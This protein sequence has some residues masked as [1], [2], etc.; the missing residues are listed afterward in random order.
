MVYKSMVATLIQW[1]LYPFLSVWLSNSNFY[2]KPFVYSSQILVH[3]T[4]I[5][6]IDIPTRCTGPSSS[7]RWV[8]FTRTSRLHTAV[9]FTKPDM[10]RKELCH[11]VLDMPSIQRIHTTTR[12]LQSNCR[13][14]TVFNIC[15][16]RLYTARR[17][18][19]SIAVKTK[20]DC[21][22]RRSPM[23]TI[24]RLGNSTSKLAFKQKQM[25]FIRLAIA[26]VCTGSVYS[27]DQISR[28]ITI[29][30]REEGVSIQTIVI[31]W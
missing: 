12:I 24:T 15:I 29:M 20:R 10:A 1:I 6:P 3:W 21:D 27:I 18:V 19:T 23:G 11:A 8:M 28:D 26:T 5:T 16:R 13:R 31:T 2:A 30:F 22:T 17:W 9:P 14:P 4:A 25:D 7:S